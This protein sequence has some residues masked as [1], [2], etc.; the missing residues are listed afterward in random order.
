MSVSSLKHL[1]LGTGGTGASSC[2]CS[3]PPEGNEMGCG[4][5][6]PGVNE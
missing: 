3:V 5:G 6:V 2:A 1:F 4:T